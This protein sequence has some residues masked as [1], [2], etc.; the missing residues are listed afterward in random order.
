M[1]QTKSGWIDISQCKGMWWG[2][3][4]SRSLGALSSH[5]SDNI[6]L[7]IFE[8]TT[9]LEEIANDHSDRQKPEAVETSCMLGE[10]R[11]DWR[12]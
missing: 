2:M 5:S 7:Q 8:P 4:V 9:V 3:R 10:S 11:T 12:R 1:N 6:D